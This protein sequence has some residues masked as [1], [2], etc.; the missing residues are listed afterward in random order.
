VVNHIKIEKTIYVGGVE[1]VFAVQQ[2]DDDN[3][4][5]YFNVKYADKD[6]A[7]EYD[8]RYDGTLKKWY[9]YKKDYKK[10]SSIVE[11]RWTR[12]NI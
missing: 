11:S 5:F 3:T 2:E 10:N 9:W 6:D 8:A 7:K 4:K 1:T 12:I